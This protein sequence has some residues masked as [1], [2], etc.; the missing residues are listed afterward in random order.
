MLKE[1]ER[2]KMHAAI[3]P[4]LLCCTKVGGELRRNLAS[5]IRNGV[6]GQIIAA[7]L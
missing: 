3:P 1:R 2:G 6:C 7:N 5:R 4:S